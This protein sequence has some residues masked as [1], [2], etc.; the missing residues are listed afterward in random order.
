M[1]VES[2]Q[3]KQER[4]TKIIAWV[5]LAIIASAVAGILIFMNV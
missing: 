4:K 5:T 1:K 2:H 3:Q